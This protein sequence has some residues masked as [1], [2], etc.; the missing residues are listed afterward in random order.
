MYKIDFYLKKTNWLGERMP[1]TKKNKNIAL[2]QL[3]K[4]N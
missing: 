2:V 4:I 1:M 3:E